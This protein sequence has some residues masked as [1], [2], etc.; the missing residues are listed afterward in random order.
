MLSEESLSGKFARS[1]RRFKL[2]GFLYLLWRLSLL[3]KSFNI[4]AHYCLNGVRMVKVFCGLR[5]I[6]VE[7][8]LFL[9]GLLYLLFVMVG[10]LVFCLGL[11]SF[12]VV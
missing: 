1:S 11:Y 5:S 6:L 7:V 10:S 4:V 8:V 2:S 9:L 12:V 3:L